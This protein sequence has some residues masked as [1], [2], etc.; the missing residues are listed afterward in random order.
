VD[1]QSPTG[2]HVT[3]VELAAQALRDPAMLQAALDAFEAAPAGSS[4]RTR[5]AALLTLACVQRA[6]GLPSHEN[7]ERVRALAEIANEDPDPLPGWAQ[8]YAAL[9]AR[10]LLVTSGPAA[11]AAFRP[12][13]VLA[14]V[15]GLMEHLENSPPELKGAFGLA[16]E[17]TRAAFTG[18]STA[19]DTDLGGAEQ[20]L[21]L[22]EAQLWMI[23]GCEPP[24]TMPFDL[25]ASAADRPTADAA[26][27]AAF[28]HAG[29]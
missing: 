13:A 25:R 8:L 29:R 14:E 19:M 10:E 24:E 12:R 11:S 9:R 26:V 21:A 3:L 22:R 4:G 27:W 17:A 5:A 7:L 18:L 6:V 23:G 20:S 28:V 15:E 16:L 1:Q 2:A